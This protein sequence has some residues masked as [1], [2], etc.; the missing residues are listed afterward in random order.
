MKRRYIV[1]NLLR[2]LVVLIIIPVIVFYFLTRSRVDYVT[3]EFYREVKSIYQEG[4]SVK[5]QIEEDVPV[6]LTVPVKDFVDMEKIIPEEIPYSAVV[7]IKTT[8]RINQN[9]S[10]PIEIPLLGKY[11][12]SV[13]LDLD[14]PVDQ[15][16]SF[17]STIKIDSSLFSSTDEVIYINQ[18]IPISIP[19]E[20]KIIPRDLGLG[21]EVESA[22]MVINNIRF[23]FFLNKIL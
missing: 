18:N 20:V 16:V 23:I 11:M 9:V 5:V 13:P 19:I 12:V 2:L 7:P 21:E 17:S 6:S 10:I 22:L 4:L 14:V 1:E 8:V 15:K 3:K